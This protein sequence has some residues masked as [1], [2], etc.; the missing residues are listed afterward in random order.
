MKQEEL[1]KI[2]LYYHDKPVLF[3]RD[4]LNAELDDQQVELVSQVQRGC[5]ICVKSSKGTGKTFV[6]AG[7][8]F[9]FLLCHP[10]CAVRVMSPSYDQLIDVFMREARMHHQRMIKPIGELFEVKFDKIHL[11]DDV[12]QIVLCISAKSTKKERQSGAHAFTQVY[13]FDE[14]SGIPDETFSN[15]IGSLGTAAGQGY[16]IAVSNPERGSEPFYQ[17]LFVKKPRG[18]SL[19][20]FTAFRSKQTTKAF[21]EEIR[22]LYGEDSDE[23][24]VM[25]LGEFPLSDGSMY[26]PM[27][28]VDSAVERTV[29]VESWMPYPT[30]IGADIA[31]SQSGDKTVFVARKGYKVT[32][33]VSFQTG[34]TMETVAKL[35]ELYKNTQAIVIYMDADGVGGPVADRCRQIGLPV[36]DV[37]GSLPSIDPRQYANTRT[38]LWGEMREWLQRGDI[39][40]HHELREELGNMKWGYNG[41]MA[42][43][44]VAKRKMTDAQ[45][46]K[47]H[48]P[49][50]ADALAF[51]FFQS[52]TTVSRRATRAK[53]IR[54]KQWS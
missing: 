1:T 49:D 34:D 36:V 2:Q 13:L 14:A 50:F 8:S 44:L 19:L 53:P 7:L 22:E 11:K 18:W 45:G 4:I 35:Q 9:W 12:N 43:Q 31:R 40:M 25:I 47:V 27:S 48:S 52:I 33:I 41:V 17:N 32:D 38:Q 30:I 42:E 26:I 5:R 39:P 51:T 6:I 20:T 10:S 28:V 23:W 16:V 21:I 54:R 29:P 24:R 3:F 37:R 46:R 15:A